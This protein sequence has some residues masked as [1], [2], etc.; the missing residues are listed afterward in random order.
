MHLVIDG[1]GGDPQ[2]MEDAGFVR[3][4]LETYPAAIGMTR[5]S[6]P[7]VIEY[8]GPKQEDWGISGFVF[9]AESHI[10]VH[11]FPYRGYINIDVFSCKAFDTER[12]LR[13]IK[14]FFSLERVR[15][16]VLERG[17]EYLERGGAVGEQVRL[18]D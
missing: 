15:S 10:S 3:H 16:W 1:Y 17:L 18:G 4:F 14:D 6:S 13:D 11:T 9:I 5:I 2:K 7:F 12:V 8:K